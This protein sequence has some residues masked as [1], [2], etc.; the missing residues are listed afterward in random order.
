MLF[1]K[2]IQINTKFN[3]D[4]KNYQVFNNTVH[5][6]G[7]DMNGQ[8]ISSDASADVMAGISDGSNPDV[9]VGNQY[10]P[11]HTG[12]K[13]D[14][15]ASN[16]KLA[17]P[18]ETFYDSKIIHFRFGLVPW[19]A[20]SRDKDF[21]SYEVN[22]QIDDHLNLR[23]LYIPRLNYS[24]DTLVQE[25]RTVY[26]K[27]EIYV[28]M[29]GSE[30]KLTDFVTPDSGIKT[31]K[32]SDYGIAEG[33][34]I[35]SF[36]VHFTEYPAGGINYGGIDT[37]YSI[38][39]GYVGDIKNN[40]IYDVHGYTA[41][42]EAVHWSNDPS[43]N[44]DNNPG[45][46]DDISATSGSRTAHVIA[47][48]SDSVPIA[49]SEIHFDTNKNGIVEAGNNRITGRFAVDE[50]SAQSMTKP[51]SAMAVLPTGVKIDTKNPEYRL[52]NNI[53]WDD[54][55]TDGN[56]ENG[57]ISIVTDDYNHTGRQLVK[58]E[59]KVTELSASDVVSYGF[60][61]I[62]DKNA[63]TPLRMDTYGFSGDDKLAVPD[64]ASTITDSYLQTDSDDL[65][66]DGN[67]TQPRVLSSNQYRMI[68]ENQIQTE[69][70]VKGEKDTNF[71]K[72][73]H[74]TLGGKIDYQLNMT[75]KGN[76][77]GNFVMMDVLPSENDL[78]ITDNTDRGSKFTPV[79]TGPITVP[80]E[81]Q[82]KVTIEY[83]EAMNPSRQDLDKDVNY[84]ST[85]DHLVDPAGAQAPNWKAE[86]EVTDWS[87][88]HSYIV[89][90][91]DGQWTQGDKIALTFS[92]KA[93]EKLSSD[94]TNP[95]IDEKIRAAWNSFA[96]SANNSQVVEPERVGVVVDYVGSVI[97]T[98]TDGKT[99]EE[100][101]GAEFELQDKD[102]K[103]ILEGLTTDDKGQIKVDNLAPGDYQF[104][105]TKAPKDY[106]LDSTPVPFT[107][108]N[109]QTEA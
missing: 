36:R 99:G 58:V 90:L 105:E 28:T 27:G 97:L 16:D 79:L 95:K 11:W 56:N 67:T 84:P 40:V 74:T 55:T 81:W 33:T 2:E 85:T 41:K 8:T 35:Q 83:S 47:P 69:K 22:Y 5:T 50:S 71:S 30:R 77:V 49:K 7:T 3:D 46:F 1:E 82:D 60:N 63:P 25:D 17:N 14:G 43:K 13:K 4:I 76:T 102:G 61:T 100:L 93:P 106:Q 57:K 48:P 62:I 107:I 15:K 89:H 80:N 98:K 18:D 38:E 65:N 72:F 109:D 94:L 88:I 12:P 59:W 31:I 92:M 21:D 104:V 70:L 96:Y 73:G 64:G 9:P 91:N 68:K 42:N 75:N 24:P 108:K 34:H 44:P 26:A 19:M 37:D 86:K 103:A 51:I 32:L 6:E 78:G 39:K 54:A 53:F 45:N 29:N 20:N 10:M 101:K 23:N 66:G 87:K 52:N